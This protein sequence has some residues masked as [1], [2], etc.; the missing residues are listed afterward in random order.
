MLMVLHSSITAHSLRRSLKPCRRHVDAVFATH[1]DESGTDNLPQVVGKL[2]QLR[3]DQLFQ[4]ASDLGN[5]LLIGSW[6]VLPVFQDVLVEV[7]LPQFRRVAGEVP[8]AARSV[9]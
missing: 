9:Q 6:I 8:S 7:P 3:L 4:V 2:L 1:V 5:L